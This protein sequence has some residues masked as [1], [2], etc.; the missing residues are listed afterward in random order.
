MLRGKVDFI[1]GFLKRYQ[2]EFGFTL[3]N[4]SVLVDDVR[5]RG[6]G[7]TDFSKEEDLTES[8]TKSP[9]PLETVQV[10]FDQR[11]EP[12]D[13]YT[14]EQLTHGHVLLGPAIVMDKLS[15]ILV[16]PGCTCIV[17]KQGNLKIEIGLQTVEKIGKELDSV[18]LSVF[19]H[20][21]MSIAGK[22]SKALL[23][24]TSKAIFQMLNS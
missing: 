22:L 11:Y 10:F 21:F 7:C 20:R 1:T 3:Q 23:S 8:Q 5:V 9:T 17:S 24:W 14:M 12:T 4:R 6:V 18:Q 2:T 13:V 16:E 15:T 19:S